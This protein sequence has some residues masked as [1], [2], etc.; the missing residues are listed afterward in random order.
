MADYQKNYDYNNYDVAGTINFEQNVVLPAYK[1]MYGWMAAALSLSALTSYLIMRELFLSD[2]FASIFF[3]SAMRWILILGSFGLVMSISGIIHRLSVS[4]ASLLF[5]LY[6]VV[7][8]AWITPFLLLFTGSSV[9]QVFL[10][11][12]G[13]FAGMAV[14]GHFTKRDLSKIGQICIMGLWGLI[15]ASLVNLFF[16][17]SMVQY[18]VSYI[19]V[20]IFCGLTMW[21]VQRF[22]ELI[23]NS[24]D[25]DQTTIQ[26]FALLGALNLYLDFMNMF[27]YLLRILGERK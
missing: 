14:Y 12:A 6:S 13:T 21:D 24:P 8:G 1:N 27:I 4:T 3:S 17:N 19:G 15:L 9:C 20:A 5:A 22:R 2:T 26:K 10:I 18:I 11:T 7:M 23:Y 16:G 25:A